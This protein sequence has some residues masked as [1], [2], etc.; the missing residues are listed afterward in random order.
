MFGHMG[1]E[2]VRRSDA[3]GLSGD[4]GLRSLIEN[5]WET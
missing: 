2:A 5:E 4:H 1:D 3:E